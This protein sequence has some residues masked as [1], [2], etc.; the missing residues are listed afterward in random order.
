MRRSFLNSKE[1][2]VCIQYIDIL[3][4]C[5][6]VGARD[7]ILQFICTKGYELKEKLFIIKYLNS[8]FS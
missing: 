5:K 4:N 2:R 1:H 6:E 8:Y 7:Q 3:K